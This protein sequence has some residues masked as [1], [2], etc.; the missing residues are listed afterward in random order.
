MNLTQAAT[1]GSAQAIPHCRP[2]PRLVG[3]NAARGRCCFLGSETETNSVVGNSGQLSGSEV[4]AIV[5]TV[6]ITQAPRNKALFHNELHCESIPQ[7][8]YAE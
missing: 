5:S 2:R 6:M 8:G 7:M 4:V 3:K 1:G